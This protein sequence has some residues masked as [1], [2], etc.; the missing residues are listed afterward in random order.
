[1]TI[2]GRFHVPA[3]S[4][5]LRETLQSNPDA[6]IKFVR[7]TI[8]PSVLSPYLWVSAPDGS[9]VRDD[10]ADD[11]TV[12]DIHEIDEFGGSA[13]YR[14]EWSD[15][16]RELAAPLTDVQG[17]ILRTFGT[18]DGWQL[19]VNFPTRDAFDDFRS[20]L[21]ESDV[22]FRTLQLSSTSGS[23]TGEPF[24][25]TPKQTT[26]LLAVWEHGYF[27]IP[28][29]TTL[30]T[31]AAELGISQQSLSERLVRGYSTLVRNT[32]A[33]PDRLDVEVVESKPKSESDFDRGI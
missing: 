31:L 24:D 20:A 29:Q 5:P 6:Q 14:V 30:E 11:P 21:R 33:T 3:E 23:H 10:A 15:S 16:A 26:A 25:L 7:V 28:K 9:G 32:L 13:L 8:S 17:T 1:M 18:V 2:S 27:E 4:F 12:E 19:S 22:E